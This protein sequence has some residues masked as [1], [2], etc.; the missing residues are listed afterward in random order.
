[1]KEKEIIV[2][3]VYQS[4][5][6]SLLWVVVTI[7]CV[8][9]FTSLADVVKT[10]FLHSN[11]YRTQRESALMPFIF[12]PFMF[13]I[14]L[15]GIA[16]T[17]GCSQ[18]VQALLAK[19]LMKKYGSRSLYGIVLSVPLVAVLSWYCYDYL[20]PS[21]VNL[22]IN[23]GPEWRPYQH[24]LTMGR[25][26]SMLEFQSFKGIHTLSVRITNNFNKN[27]LFPY[28]I[29]NTKYNSSYFPKILP[30]GNVNETSKHLSF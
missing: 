6:K 14:A 30:A 20:T 28:F 4:F 3:K 26:L 15:F 23:A 12:T 1:M 16:L 8:V 25:Y 13:I 17:F 19:N 18:F 29:L 10:D 9:F 22:G 5:F 24:G 7:T 11:P 2:D 21:D 27:P